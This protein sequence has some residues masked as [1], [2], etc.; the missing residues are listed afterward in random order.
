MKRSEFYS[1]KTLWSDVCHKQFVSLA[2][3]EMFHL[4]KIDEQ[5]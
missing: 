2:P 4:F 5:N 3:E 1:T